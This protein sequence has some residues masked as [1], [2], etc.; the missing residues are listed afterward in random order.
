MDRI[1]L[2]VRREIGI[3]D[4]SSQEDSMSNAAEKKGEEME[5]GFNESELQDIMNEIEN[6]EK[7]F[8][9]DSHAQ[10]EVAAVAEEVAEEEAA[11]DSAEMQS[12]VDEVEALESAPA[13]AKKVQPIRA[14]SGGK[15]MSF[16]G[17][18]T[19]NFSMSFDLGETPVHFSIDPV[20]GVTLSMDHVEFCMTEDSCVVKM[21]GGVTFNVPM[22]QKAKKNA[23]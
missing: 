14:A 16:S 15:E 13:P 7:E 20:S 2:K 1:E 10:E 22:S 18:G 3:S 19:L 11:F 21:P 12:I 6:L 17:A 9:D 23:A 5:Q 4:A 8:S